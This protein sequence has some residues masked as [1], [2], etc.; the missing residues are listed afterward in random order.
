[1]GFMTT[2]RAGGMRKAPKRGLWVVLLEFQFA[3]AAVAL[4]LFLLLDVLADLRF[5][6]A[7]GADAITPGPERPAECSPTSRE[8]DSANPS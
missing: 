6:Q 7:N 8:L 4:L 3:L 1:M 2:G 5:I